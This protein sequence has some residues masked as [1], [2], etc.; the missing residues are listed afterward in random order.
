M[1]KNT[2]YISDLDGTL[3]NSQCQIDEISAKI[4]NKL[5]QSGLKFSIATARTNKTV[6]QLCADIN[7][8]IPVILMNGVAIFDMKSQKFISFESFDEQVINIFFDIVSDFGNSGFLYT[9]ENGELETFYVNTNAPNAEEF[10]RERMEKYGKKFHKITSFKNC[11]NMK[12]VHYSVSH[13]ADILQPLYKK[14][15]TLKSFSVE[16]YRDIYN[17]DFW[18]LEVCSAKASKYNAA[19][20]LK[21]ML[22]CEKIVAFGDNLNDLPLFKAADECYAVANAKNEVKEKATGIIG[23]NNDNGV[24]KF[25]QNTYIISK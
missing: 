7:I 22:Q 10:M 25:L 19:L 3:L 18:Y 5:I 2:L 21:N 11:A 16:F 14:L 17:D 20:K 4:I 15:C 8:N 9:I 13:K 24:A 1:N 23:S 12:C 6:Q